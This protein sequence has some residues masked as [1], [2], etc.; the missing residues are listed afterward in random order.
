MRRER[1]QAVVELIALLPLLAAGALAAGAFLIS[2]LTGEL[3]DRAAQAAAVALLQDRD[4]DRAAR[5]AVPG[6]A[7]GS[8]SVTVSGTRVSV[9]LSPPSLGRRIGA[10]VA[11]RAVAHAGTGER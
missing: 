4:P 2:V 3:A 7:R 5:D 11:G 10:V 9:V 8:L 6:W 1:G